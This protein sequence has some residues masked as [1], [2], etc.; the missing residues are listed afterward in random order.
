MFV[1]LDFALLVIA[2]LAEKEWEKQEK[3]EQKLVHDLPFPP[4][5]LVE[6][7]WYEV[8]VEK[9]TLIHDLSQKFV[10]NYPFCWTNGFTSYALLKCNEHIG[11]TIG[12]GPWNRHKWLYGAKHSQGNE[13]RLYRIWKWSELHHINRTAVALNQWHGHLHKYCFKHLFCNLF[14]SGIRWAFTGPLVLWFYFMIWY[15]CYSVGIGMS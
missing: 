13:S 3:N 15:P 5:F 2:V 8:R 9:W 1:L 14:S 10:S 4:T 11:N 12:T 7:K 6:K